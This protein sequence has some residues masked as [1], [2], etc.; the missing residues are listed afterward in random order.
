MKGFENFGKEKFL[1]RNS[2][3]VGGGD[4]ICAELERRI[5]LG[6]GKEMELGIPLPAYN[7]PSPSLFA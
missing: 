6:R 1:A 2:G 7:F 4:L 5:A 3:K